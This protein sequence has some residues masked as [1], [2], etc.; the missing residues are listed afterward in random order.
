MHRLEHAHNFYRDEFGK[1]AEL[2]NALKSKTARKEDMSTLL[3]RLELAGK[4]LE[5]FQVEIEQ[6]VPMQQFIV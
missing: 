2:K 3:V 5:H 4:L 1:Y 6:H